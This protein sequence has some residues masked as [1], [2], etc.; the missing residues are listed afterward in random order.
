MTT[1]DTSPPPSTGQEGWAADVLAHQ[2]HA[3]TIPS[4]VPRWAIPSN[5]GQHDAHAYAQGVLFVGR[6]DPDIARVDD[7]LNVPVA[8]RALAIGRRAIGPREH[9]P[10]TTEAEHRAQ[11]AVYCGLPLLAG[12]VVARAQ[13]ALAADDPLLHPAIHELVQRMWPNRSTASPP[14]SAGV[15]KAALSL[16]RHLQ[17]YGDAGIPFLPDLAKVGRADGST[18]AP[19]LREL[20][21]R[22]I[23]STRPLLQSAFGRAMHTGLTEILAEPAQPNR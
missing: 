17:Q 19:S 16:N 7:S 5:V 6:Y 2:L 13:L 20:L 3:G 9:A 8:K 1:P 21:R 22:V 11:V 14:G 15:L 10:G 4:T 12:H 23:Y 18:Y